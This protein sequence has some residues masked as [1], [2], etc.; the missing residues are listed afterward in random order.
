VSKEV[1]A[2]KRIG[3]AWRVIGWLLCIAWAPV[4]VD[5]LLETV[6]HFAQG[7]RTYDAVFIWIIPYMEFITLP[8]TFLAV[9]AFL[10]KAAK[11]TVRSFQNN[12]SAK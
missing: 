4:F 2:M 5:E 10:F 11:E 9:L 1:L 7:T 6:F 8:L 12:K 3:L